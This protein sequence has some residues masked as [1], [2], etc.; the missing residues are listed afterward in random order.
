MTNQGLPDDTGTRRDH[1]FIG[2]R[3]KIEKETCFYQVHVGMLDIPGSSLSQNFFCTRSQQRLCMDTQ[4][5]QLW[6]QIMHSWSRSSGNWK[7][8]LNH[9]QT[10]DLGKNRLWNINSS[11]N[12]P[13]ACEKCY[14]YPKGQW[15]KI[16]LGNTSKYSEKSAFMTLLRISSLFLVLFG[17]FYDFLKP[18]HLSLMQAPPRAISICLSFVNLLVSFTLHLAVPRLPSWS[19]KLREQG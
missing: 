19:F 14:S 7:E 13:W 9:R 17:E 18:P 3:Q 6:V 12:E 15:G 10:V 5:S 8:N 2:A 11:S 4:S 16:T 1:K